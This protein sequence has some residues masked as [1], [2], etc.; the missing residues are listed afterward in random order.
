MRLICAS[1][2]SQF[3]CYF[4]FSCFCISNARGAP[5]RPFPRATHTYPREPRRYGHEPQKSSVVLLHTQ[6]S[7][8]VCSSLTYTNVKSLLKFP[9]IHKS[10]KPSVVSL[11]TQM[12]KVLYRSSHS[13]YISALTFQETKITRRHGHKNVFETDPFGYVVRYLEEGVAGS[14]RQQASRFV[15]KKKS[16]K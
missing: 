16:N 3:V 14:P 6:M 1:T 5:A 15:L 10:Q 13:R 2:N 4:R 12:S 11:H 8:V 9:C 7:K